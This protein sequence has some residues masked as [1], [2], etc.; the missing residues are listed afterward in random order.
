MYTFFTTLHK[1]THCTFICPLRLF[2]LEHI[3]FLYIFMRSAV[4]KS[5]ISAIQHSPV[6]F[7]FFFLS[8]VYIWNVTTLTLF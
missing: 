4:I 5:R 2:L 6:F 3:Y 8:I 1:T 7:C